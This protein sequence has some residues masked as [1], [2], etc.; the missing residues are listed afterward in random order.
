MWDSIPRNLFSKLNSIVLF[1]TCGVFVFTVILVG[2]QWI[3]LRV[4]CVY[5]VILTSGCRI[6]AFKVNIYL[7]EL[8]YSASVVPVAN[9]TSVISSPFH[10]RTVPA[11]PKRSSDLLPAL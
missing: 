1:A 8:L 7:S 10:Y 3:L 5:I 4:A 6:T 2:K 11:T 9:V